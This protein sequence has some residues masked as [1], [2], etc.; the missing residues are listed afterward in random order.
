MITNDYCN[1][2][3]RRRYTWKMP[4]DISIYQINYIMVRKRFKN[5]VK[6]CRTYPG[7]D[8]DSDQTY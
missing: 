1:H 5:Q 4:G 6:D 8:I 3:P 7:V 2:H